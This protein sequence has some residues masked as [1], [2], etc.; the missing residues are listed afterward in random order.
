MFLLDPSSLST[1]GPEYFNIDEARREFQNSLH[2]Y[3][4][5]LK[6]D[7]NKSI[8]KIYE[9]TPRNEMNERISTTKVEVES[10]KK[11]QFERKLE[12]KKMYK[13][14][15]ERQKEIEPRKKT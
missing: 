10:I 11:T 7:M 9:N 14:K 13:L 2:E 12:I 6:E 8:Y 15:Q 1:V 4:E 3:V 5:V